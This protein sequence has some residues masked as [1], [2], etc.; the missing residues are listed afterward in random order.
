MF[1]G[2]YNYTVIIT[3]LS[4]I[5]AGMGMYFS[6]N[7]NF[8]AALFCLLLSG[9]CDMIDGPVARTRKRTETEKKFGIQIDSLCDLVSFGIQ[10]AVLVYFIAEYYSGSP[11]NIIALI[12]GLT[13]AL[14]AVIRLAYF[15]VTEEERQEKE[16]G[17][18]RTGYQGLPVTN[19]ALI[20]PG[21][22]NARFFTDGSLFAMIMTIG[23]AIVAFLYVFNFKMFKLNGKKL[24]PVGIFGVAILVACFF[25]P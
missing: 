3:Y 16:G 20:I 10:P 9:L 13:F 1:V 7:G 19:S 2:I 12:V 6:A 17:K 23:L 4:L 15:N 5:S 25:T 22:Y 8:K 18:K 21:L 24:I 11:V 14:C